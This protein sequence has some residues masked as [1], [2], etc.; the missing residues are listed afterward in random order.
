MFVW[1]PMYFPSVRIYSFCIYNSYN[2]SLLYGSVKHPPAILQ[3]II[4]SYS[5]IEQIIP[6]IVFDFVYLEVSVCNI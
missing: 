5:F 1:K 2:S 6:V 3:I 4:A